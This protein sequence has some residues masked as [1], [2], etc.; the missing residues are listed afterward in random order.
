M[1]DDADIFKISKLLEELPKVFFLWVKGQVSKEDNQV[2]KKVNLQKWDPGVPAV[3]QRIK[4]PTA[5]AQVN[6]GG[7]GLIPGQVQW[8]RETALP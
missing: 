4:T 5:G 7:K 3:V 8:V 6:N 2:G 1:Q